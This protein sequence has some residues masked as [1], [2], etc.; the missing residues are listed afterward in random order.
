MNETSDG[1]A[2]MAIQLA[3]FTGSQRKLSQVV[4]LVEIEAD[5]AKKKISNDPNSRVREA[6]LP[7]MS[8]EY[9]R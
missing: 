7:R 3:K 4:N 2:M 5:L 6:Q 9:Q 8:V 1:Y